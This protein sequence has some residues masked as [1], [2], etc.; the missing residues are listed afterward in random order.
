MTRSRIVCIG[1]SAGSLTALQQLL[2][3]LHASWGGTVVVTVHQHPAQH[4]LKQALEPY[5]L[6]PVEMPE[7]KQAIA[8]G[9]IYVAPPNYHLL[10]EADESFSLSVDPLVKYSRPSVDVFFES[11]ARALGSWVVGVL[12]SGA[13][14]DG[15]RGLAAIQRRGGIVGCQSP[16]SAEQAAM[17]AAGIGAC[18]PD[19]IA[20][21]LALG[22]FVSE[23]PTEAPDPN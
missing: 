10:I 16:Q 14:D 9:K 2:P 15:A 21:P 8:R 3:Q 7:D 19:I 1:G 23:L 18:A 5:A 4:G 22:R 12:L 6:L 11:A 13:N 17:P 20:D